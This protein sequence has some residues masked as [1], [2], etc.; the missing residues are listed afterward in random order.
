[1]SIK[2]AKNIIC[3][4]FK[5]EETDKLIQNWFFIVFATL[6]NRKLKTFFKVDKFL[7]KLKK[8]HFYIFLIDL[9]IFLS[10]SHYAFISIV[11]F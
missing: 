11:V 6:T 10:V 7:G 2:F 4:V 1:M 8:G 5:N 9:V 3:K